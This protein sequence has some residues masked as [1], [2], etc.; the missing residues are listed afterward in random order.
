MERHNS[1]DICSDCSAAG[2]LRG[3]RRA[4]GP[5]TAQI[6]ARERRGMTRTKA[7]MLTSVSAHGR[8]SPRVRL[9]KQTHEV[10]DAVTKHS[11]WHGAAFAT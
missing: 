8:T 7:H 3:L 4:S 5:L 1:F 11:D 10:T 9:R 6:S 2:P